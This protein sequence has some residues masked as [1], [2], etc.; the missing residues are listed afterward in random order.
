MPRTCVSAAAPG[1]PDEPRLPRRSL[2]AALPAAGA[3]ALTTPS[4]AQ[5][6]EGDTEIMRLFRQHRAILKARSDHVFRGDFATE[7]EELEALFCRDADTLEKSIMA[8]PSTCAADFAAKMIVS[9]VCGNLLDDWEGGQV[10]KE[11]RSLT[12]LH[13]DGYRMT[14]CVQP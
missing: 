14:S 3:L 6:D 9:S 7:D 8:L 4:L 10:W 12:G 1:L 5:A 2:L 13:I 11:A